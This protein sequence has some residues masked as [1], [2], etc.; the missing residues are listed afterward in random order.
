[1]KNGE[2]SDDEFYR[3]IIDK[4]DWSNP[5]EF[6]EPLRNLVNKN[7]VES[8]SLLAIILGDIDS[9]LYR[10]EIMR[11]NE[12]AFN[13]GSVVAAEN[14]SIQYAQWGE[15]FLSRLWLSRAKKE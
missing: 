10:D 8:M 11:I 3:N 2:I 14:L 4:L 12:A 15:E 9:N 5:H 6:I 7:H 1:M 13:L